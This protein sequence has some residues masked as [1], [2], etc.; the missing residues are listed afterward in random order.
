MSESMT[1]RRPLLIQHRSQRPG[2]NR[3]PLLRAAATAAL[4]VLLA[5]AGATRAAPVSWGGPATGSWASTGFWST[6]QQPGA[7]D[8]VSITFA[9]AGTQTIVMDTIYPA[10]NGINSLFV[11]GP[12]S[13]TTTLSQ[14]S[15]FSRL[16]VT[17]GQTI[18]SSGQATYAQGGGTNAVGGDL[19][20][21]NAAGSAG[22]YNL[23]GGTLTVAGVESIAASGTG[24]FGQSGGQ[25]T[26]KYVHMADASGSTGTYQ[27]DGGSYTV[28]GDEHVGFNGT[29]TFTQT[30]G[31]HTVNGDNVFATT[32]L[33][34]GHDSTGIGTYNLNGGALSVSNSLS[35]G[36]S[37]S[38]TFKQDSGSN[39]VGGSL[40]LGQNAGSTGNYNLTDGALTVG[41]GAASQTRDEFVGNSGT[42]AFVQ[43]GG[44][45]DV[46]FILYIGNNETGTGSYQLSN[47]TLNVKDLPTYVG[48]RGAGTFTQFNGVYNAA[49]LNLGALAGGDGTFNGS[50]GTDNIANT[51]IGGTA[52]GPGG[53]GRI[54]LM[55]HLRPA[56][57]N[58]G[59]LTLYPNTGSSGASVL[60]DS[61][62]GT[63]LN[64]TS[65]KLGD[66]SQLRIKGG[67]FHLSGGTATASGS[68]VIG[69]PG[70]VAG[71]FVQSGAT[72]SVKADQLL[73]GTTAGSE[74]N[75]VL[76]GGTFRTNATALGPVTGDTNFTGHF[77]QTGGAHVTTELE[78]APNWANGVYDL[79]DGSLTTTRTKV[80]PLPG[81][82]NRFVTGAFN[83]SGGTH[84]ASALAVNGSWN[85]VTYTLSGGQLTAD[86]V[87]VYAAANFSG[88]FGQGRFV[89]TG[90]SAR[91]GGTNGLRIY[92]TAAY[93][94]SGAGTLQVDNTVTVG[95]D[96]PGTFT[97][98]GGTVTVGVRLAIGDSTGAGGYTLSGG[99]LSAPT[100]DL[101]KGGADATFD[102]SDTGRLNVTSF[103]VHPSG[104]LTVF[105]GTVTGTIN[106][107]GAVTLAGR[108]IAAS[109]NN[110]GGGTIT[111]LG[112]TVSGAITNNA[113]ATVSGLGHIAADL[114]NAGTVRLVGST[115]LSGKLTNQPGGLASI[116]TGQFHVTGAA[117]NDGTIRA[118]YGGQAAFD[119]G[120]AG[121]PVKLAPSRYAGD[122]QLQLGGSLLA[123]YVR[124]H[125]LSLTGTP[126]DPASYAK[127]QIRPK[128]DGGDTSVLSSLT[129]AADAQGRLLGKLDL[130]DNALVVEYTANSPIDSIRD[131]L[132]SAYAGGTWSGPAGLTSS[133]AAVDTSKA[134]GY[135]QASDLGSPATFAGQ[136]VDNSAV[137][138]RYTLAGD[139]TLDGRVDFND[140]VN[141]AQHYNATGQHWLGGD[142]D[143]DGTVNFNDLVKLAQNYNGSL[144]GSAAIASAS[145]SFESD[146]VAA[147]A[148]PV[149]EP[150]TLFVLAAAALAVRSRRRPSPRKA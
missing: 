90:G 10:T 79:E 45:H 9:T 28:N 48:Y 104:T 103:N 19:I 7:A 136:A 42:G 118:S 33:I 82:D 143:Y 17:G 26:A 114:T 147:F 141:L 132:A 77:T 22:T 134:L 142:F 20:L 18:G 105:D 38:G 85:H 12:I 51:Y 83:Q 31:T 89:Q 44:T 144:P 62:E 46:K 25:H 112:G 87:D 93:E 107:R 94:L 16:S 39:T 53:S 86:Q 78:V 65:L 1:R 130:A 61:I 67:T 70:E 140:L 47:G 129:I 133:L 73:L 2:R 41:T 127:V 55:G 117:L 96:T 59:N 99:T 13:G 32:G 148:A 14:T 102:L 91:V 52:D 72:T 71:T 120:L 64:A 34:L 126:G 11:N 80:G 88:V 3:R 36:R 110:N 50:G 81:N 35:V 98:S 4:G 43:R 138:V 108:G 125:G 66:W 74:G 58:V 97:Q 29:A 128:A 27:L 106:N 121:T 113:G 21:G 109:V 49:S 95:L 76:Q 139:A 123:S 145:A 24:S 116:A 63:A 69:D 30:A 146:L 5:R 68:I 92:G 75:F 119:Q 40:L 111:L 115:Q 15:L 150:S 131:A 60:I 149:P 124:Q 56:D 37:G 137:L 101:G 84:L 100:V 6:H 122:V 57:V 8:D 23:T 54:I 135:A